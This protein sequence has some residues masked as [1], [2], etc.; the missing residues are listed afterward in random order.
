MWRPSARRRFH[1][2]AEQLHV[3]GEVFYYAVDRTQDDYWK[4]EGKGWA[5]EKEH[6]IGSPGSLGEAV[7]TLVAPGD[8][9]TVKLQKIYAAVMA[10]DNTDYS[11]EH[12]QGRRQ[13]AGLAGGQVG[14]GHLGSA[15]A[16]AATSLTS[17]LYR[18]GAAQHGMKAYDVQVTNRDN[19]LFSPVWLTLRQLMDDLAIVVLDGKEQYFDPGQPECPFGQMAWKHTSTGG[20]REATQG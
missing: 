15:S 6:F 12:V 7:S 9:D 1:A 2:A 16:E 4:N 14:A 18:P 17:A 5:K 13:G 10:M 11:R 20:L 3:P 8:T 19:N